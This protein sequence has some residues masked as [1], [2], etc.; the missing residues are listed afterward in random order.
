MGIL[1]NPLNSKW[2]I[3]YFHSHPPDDKK[4]NIELGFLLL[5]NFYRITVFR[6]N[7]TRPIIRRIN[8]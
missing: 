1:I 4:P 5:F 7:M 3:L 8:T 6:A 2:E